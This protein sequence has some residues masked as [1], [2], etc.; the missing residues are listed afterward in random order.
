VNWTELDKK[1]NPLAFRPPDDLTLDA[2]HAEVV[3]ARQKF[4]GNRHLL[5]ALT[6]EVGELA[7][8]ILQRRPGEEIE[9]EAIQVACVAVRIIEE[10]DSAFDDLTDAESKP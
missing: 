7:K 1:A 2:I 6:E 3:R 10:R 8:A 4:P 9:R 5:A